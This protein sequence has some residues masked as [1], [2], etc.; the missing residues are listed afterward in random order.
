MNIRIKFDSLCNLVQVER[1]AKQYLLSTGE[2]KSRRNPK[3]LELA[4]WLRQHIPLEDSSG[5]TAGLV[6][7]DFRIDNVVFHPIE[8]QSLKASD[9]F[10]LFLVTLCY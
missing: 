8:V 1:W 3:M 6:H 7:G 9:N 5:A 10:L 4:D 2:G